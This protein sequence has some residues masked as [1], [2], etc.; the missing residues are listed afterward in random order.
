ML[1]KIPRHGF[2]GGGPGVI[3]G[4][5]VCL[6]VPV[7]RDGEP[8]LNESFKILTGAEDQDLWLSESGRT[9]DAA[10]STQACHFFTRYFE[11]EL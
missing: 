6:E 2:P 4:G 9:I 8:D 10:Q 3:N 5:E 1:K 11:I 7:E